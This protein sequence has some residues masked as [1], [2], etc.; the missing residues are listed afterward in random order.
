MGH[1]RRRRHHSDGHRSRG[2]RRAPHEGR[3]GPP[4]RRRRRLTRGPR[5]DARQPREHRPSLRPG[6]A[7]GAR[8]RPT[9]SL[10]SR[11]PQR[12]LTG[13][14]RLPPVRTP[15]EHHAQSPGQQPL[16]GALSVR[17]TVPFSGLRGVSPSR[18]ATHTGQLLSW[19]RTDHTRPRRPYLRTPPRVA[20]HTSPTHRTTP[21]LGTNGPHATRA[22]LSQDSVACRHPHQPDTPDNS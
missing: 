22:P 6:R 20:T 17:P 14:R 2:A 1:G 19:G 4:D 11:P 3:R 16:P 5:D 21:E 10:R 7:H 12:A 15:A 8:A 18:E 9:R 13:R